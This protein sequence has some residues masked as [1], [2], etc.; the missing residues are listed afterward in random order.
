MAISS[1]R[2]FRGD[3]RACFHHASEKFVSDYHGV[4]NKMADASEEDLDS[5]R[6]PASELKPTVESVQLEVLNSPRKTNYS[7]DN[8]CDESFF[9]R[10]IDALARYLPNI[11]ERIYQPTAPD[12]SKD[13]WSMSAT[14]LERLCSKSSASRATGISTAMLTATSSSAS[15]PE[16]CGTAISSSANKLVGRLQDRP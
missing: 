3:A 11:E 16:R 14:Q 15:P 6:I 12:D 9:R 1:R 2:I 5:F 7:K 8:Y 4:L 13:Y 10:K